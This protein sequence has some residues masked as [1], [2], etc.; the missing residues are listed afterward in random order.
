[1]SSLPIHRPLRRL[2][3]SLAAA[4]LLVASLSVVDRPGSA[5]AAPDPTFDPL[6]DA[7]AGAV[8]GPPAAMRQPQAAWL[9]AALA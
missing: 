8:C 2:A 3:L 6:L 1:M 7:G 5:F 9:L 4:G